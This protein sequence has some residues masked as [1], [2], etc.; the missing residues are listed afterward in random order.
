MAAAREI[1]PRSQPNASR[2]GFS[3]TPGAERRP[4]AVISETKVTPTT[5][6]A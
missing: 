4:A 1:T 3:S 5:T 6:K 2:H